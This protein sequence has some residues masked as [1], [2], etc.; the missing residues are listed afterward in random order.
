MSPLDYIMCWNRQK[1]ENGDFR[2][3]FQEDI[4]VA[5]SQ[6]TANYSNS[7]F[8]VTWKKRGLWMLYIRTYTK[9]KILTLPGAYLGGG[10][11]GPGPPG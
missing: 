2:K 10:F 11:G 7:E 8:K 4:F 3:I 5:L 1:R 9:E 6:E